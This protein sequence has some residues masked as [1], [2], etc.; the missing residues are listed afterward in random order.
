[1]KHFAL[2]LHILFRLTLVATL[3][4]IALLPLVYETTVLTAFVYMPLLLTAI[5]VLNLAADHLLLKMVRASAGK[6]TGD[7]RYFFGR[8]CIFCSSY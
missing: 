5:A 6:H 7:Y 8:H 4:L 1:M 3:A 2:L